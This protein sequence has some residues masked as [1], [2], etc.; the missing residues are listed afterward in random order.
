[1]TDVSRDAPTITLAIATIGDRLA[2]ALELARRAAAQAPVV[3]VAQ[4]PPQGWEDLTSGV[5]TGVTVIADAGQGVSRSR[6]RALDAVPTGLVWLLDDDV[7]IDEGTIDR[8]VAFAARHPAD[9]YVG[10]IWAPDADAWYKPY[11]FGDP[12]GRL[13]VLRVTSIEVVLDVEFL[14]SHDL[15]FDED[16]GVGAR[17]PAGEE[18]LLLLDAF[19]A[20]AV[21][22]HIPEVIVH[23][24]RD[25]QRARTRNRDPASMMARGLVARRVGGPAGLGLA[26]RWSWRS[27]AAGG[28]RAAMACWRGHLFGRPKA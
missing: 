22:R 4:E 6:N 23:H 21:I 18:N 3:V 14:R 27:I 17:F 1:M 10:R 5:G 15:R 13:D 19:D 8:I 11:R 7:T 2:D 24:P 16:F 12:L 28:A 9:V 25:P 20:G 26:I